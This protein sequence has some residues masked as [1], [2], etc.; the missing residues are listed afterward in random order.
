MSGAVG[1]LV[2]GNT[3]NLET[4]ELGSIQPISLGFAVGEKLLDARVE[5]SGDGTGAS[6]AP[7]IDTNIIS[8]TYGK[9]VGF[10][11]ENG[12]SGYSSSSTRFHIIPVLNIVN[13]GI[14]AKLQYIRGTVESNEDERKRIDS[15]KLAKN[16]DGSDISGSGYVVAPYLRTLPFYRFIEDWNRLPLADTDLPTSSIEPFDIKINL[17]AD[18]LTSGARLFG[19]FTQAPILITLNAETTNELIESVSLVVDGQTYDDLTQD[20]IS[21]DNL[22]HFTWVPQEAQTYT[23]S[24]LVRDVTGNVISSEPSLLRSLI[25]KVEVFL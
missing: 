25:L 8:D 12:G 3:I 2:D 24:A 20:A 1:F 6:I 4:D 5:V 11:V 22:Y 10:E 13:P 21:E 18:D 19:G 14:E 15:V 9:I 7:V 23:V 17:D 16:P